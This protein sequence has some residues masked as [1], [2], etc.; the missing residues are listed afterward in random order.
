MKRFLAEHVEFFG[1][2]RHQ[3]F[4]TGAIAPSSR[5]LARTVT[6][7]VREK[8]GPARILEIGPG[9]GAVTRTL[10]TLLGPGDHLDLVELNPTFV[11]RLQ[12]RF[13]EEPRFQRVASQ[14]SIHGLPL[15]EFTSP[16]KYD[17]IISGLP[18]NNFPPQLVQEVFESYFR[19]LAPHGL[20]SFFEYMAFRPLKRYVGPKRERARMTGVNSVV[21]PFL[22]EA[23]IK[24][25]WV[26]VNFP[27]AWVQHLRW[28]DPAGLPTGNTATGSTA[29]GKTSTT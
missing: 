2:F 27:P 4:T 28:C 6:R 15:Q 5:F 14:V 18:L 21:R 7:P 1:Q 20:L 17:F 29:T 23:R 16:E 8:K 11:A 24:R 10:V 22:D 13:A 3:F 19:L 26:F 25:D 12:R 9:T